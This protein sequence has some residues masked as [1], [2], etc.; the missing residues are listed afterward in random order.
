MNRLEFVLPD[1]SR[2]AWTS[3]A[4]REIWEPRVTG[5]VS[6]WLEI[7]WRAV[8]AGV[9]RCAIATLSPENFVT[10]G[11]RWAE[12]GLTAVPLE[13]VGVS[14]QIYSATP[15]P[16]RAGEPFAMRFVVGRPADAAAFHAAFV[17][18]DDET[19]GDLL[20]YP[21]CCREFFR[22]TWVDDAMVDTTWPMA[23]GRSG[24]RDPHDEITEVDVDGPAYSN[25]L[26]RW[27]GV[28]AVPHLPCSFACSATVEFALRLVEVGR[29]AGF[30]QEMEWLDEILAWPAEWSALHG[31]A[32]IKT[33][34]LRVSTRTDATATKYVVRRRG[35]RFPAEGARGLSFS[36]ETP[37]KLRLSATP[38]FRRGL[39]HGAGSSPPWLAAD[40]GF[41]STAAMAAAHAPIID[42]ASAALAGNGGR[43]VDLGCGN[44]ALLA[45]LVEADPKVEPFG[46]EVDPERL[47]HAE[48]LHPDATD[49]FVCGD[50]FDAP[51]LWPNGSRFDLALVM[52]GRLL[53]VDPARAEALRDWLRQHCA[54][55]I[56]YGYGDWLNRY[57][58]LTTL[59][60][61][62]GFEV[63]ATNEPAALARI[64]GCRQSESGGSGGA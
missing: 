37:V 31:I 62:A 36:Y 49:G 35:D 59:A 3:D 64:V 6:A 45:T 27:M 58:G 34:V 55:I 24:A 52:P 28:R 54:Q 16:V 12:L 20:G 4:A 32:E 23:R 40:N 26:W 30:A 8:V 56:V 39:T 57:D 50:L 18:G 15:T 46:V 43:V 13:L 42:V 5:V 29:H 17:G 10:L 61:N 19:I 41:A 53:E 60:A 1:F 22:A 14:G 44:G 25:I 51:A 47:A 21:P 7:E 48:V 33:P 11:P 63:L 2:L 38:G 9:R